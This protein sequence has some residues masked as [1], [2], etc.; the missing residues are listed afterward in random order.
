M[1]TDFLNSDVVG[2]IEEKYIK[3]FKDE[4]W[5]MLNIAKGGVYKTI[6]RRGLI[7]ELTKDLLRKDKRKYT[8]EDIINS[9]LEC[10]SYSLFRKQYNK[11]KWQQAY[12]RNLLP[13]I[14]EVLKN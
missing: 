3:K 2:K 7:N 13:K 6:C 11:T 9:A 8:D 5:I 4:G 14:K 10:G 12:R 1:L